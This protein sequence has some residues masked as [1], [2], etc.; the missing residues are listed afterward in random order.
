[1]GSD[2]TWRAGRSAPI[3]SRAPPSD[4]T[5]FTAV[6]RLLPILLTLLL[7]GVGACGSRAEEGDDGALSDAPSTAPDDDAPDDDA[8][9]PASAQIGTVDNPCSSE[10]AGTVP[11]GVPGVSDDTIRIGVISDRQNP[12]VPLPTVGIEESIQAFVDF[13]NEAGGVDGRQ[14][15]LVTYDSEI[16][17][18][19]DVT[20]LACADDL[21]ALVGT[22]SVQDQLGVETREGCGLIEVGAYAATPERAES[23][24]FFQP[25]PAE[26]DD[27]LNVGPCL[28]I[29][30]EHPDAVK[31]A[32]IVY[33]DLRPAARRAEKWVEACEA[34]AGFDFVV[35]QPIAFGET[36]F[37]PLV[38]QMKDTGAEYFTMVSSSSEALAVL[39]EL[40]T[41]GI[42]PEVID[43]GAQYYEIDFGAQPEVDGAL[44]TTG[45]VPF[46]E[47][48]QTPA[49]GLYVDLM[50]EAGAPHST[51]GVAAFSAGMLFATAV[52]SLDGE[53]TRE[54]LVEAL[55]GIHEWDGGGMHTTTDPGTGAANPCFLYVRVEDGDFVRD[56]PDEGF[57]CD[58]DTIATV[59]EG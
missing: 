32:A 34:E 46:S 36:N 39:R 18:T 58:P 41:Q 47:A 40:E 26:H 14:L 4:V 16:V 23:T 20:K 35:N 55:S 59:A 30:E 15:D 7:V 25:L 10:V 44:V 29:A 38:Q 51:L 31:R 2:P 42:E 11:D 33:T 49:L 5:P 21:F 9:T 13:C 27:E 52:D 17:A 12:T 48:D 54:S 1:M 37:G 24:N 28:R 22:G 3:T 53:L 6:R 8:I 57:S 56:F 45:N 43:L 50:A 19:D